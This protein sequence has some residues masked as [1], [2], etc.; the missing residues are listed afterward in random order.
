MVN[1]SDMLRELADL[2]DDDFRGNLLEV[3]LK[4]SQILTWLLQANGSDQKV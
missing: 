4:L 2:L 1:Y 3:C